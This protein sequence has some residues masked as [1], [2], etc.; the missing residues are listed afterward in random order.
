M[1]HIIFVFIISGLARNYTQ[2]IAMIFIYLLNCII[3]ILKKI[4][5]LLDKDSF[6][7]IDDSVTETEVFTLAT[8]KL[9]RKEAELLTRGSFFGLNKDW[10]FDE[11]VDLTQ[12]AAVWGGRARGSSVDHWMSLN[13]SDCWHLSGLLKQQLASVTCDILFMTNGTLEGLWITGF[14]WST[15]WCT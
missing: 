13:S 9:V 5:A 7:A 15:T 12:G 1:W 11:W 14:F 3:C 6:V 4:T 8:D 2:F 10:P